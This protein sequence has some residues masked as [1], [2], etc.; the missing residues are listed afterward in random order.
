MDEEAKC[1]ATAKVV[2]KTAAEQVVDKYLKEIMPEINRA[3]EEK[4][5]SVSFSYTDALVAYSMSST[6]YELGYQ[7]MVAAKV[8]PGSEIEY[9][10]TVSWAPTSFHTAIAGK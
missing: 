5:F 2:A 1:D 4:R 9:T 3:I 7:T 6:L 8:G 10:L